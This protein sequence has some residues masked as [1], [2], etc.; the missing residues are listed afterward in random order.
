MNCNCQ[1]SKLSISDKPPQESMVF[2]PKH[3]DYPDSLFSEL[4]DEK[5]A[6]QQ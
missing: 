5:V 1:F 2:V 3:D 4:N 6:N